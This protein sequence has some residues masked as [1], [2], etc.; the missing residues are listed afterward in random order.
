MQESRENPQQKKTPESRSEKTPSATTPLATYRGR[1]GKENVIVEVYANEAR[2]KLYDNKGHS[3]EA[4]DYGP[5]AIFDKVTVME[6]GQPDEVRYLPEM[7]KKGKQDAMAAS[8]LSV[9]LNT[10]I[11]KAIRR[12]LEDLIK[13]ASGKKAVKR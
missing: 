10:A 7:M 9:G 12:P 6:A 4:V 3:V 1:I 11:E 13:E 2:M 8:I 5:D